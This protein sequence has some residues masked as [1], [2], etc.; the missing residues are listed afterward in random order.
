MGQK[1]SDEAILAALLSSPS[2]TTAAKLLHTTKQTVCRRLKSPELREK[3]EEIRRS[4]LDEAATRL[5]QT[6]TAAADTLIALLGSSNE[7]TRLNA[8][9]KI[10]SN[11][12]TYVDKYDILQ[13]L[14]RL[15]DELSDN[16]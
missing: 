3:F 1:I 12:A 10:L 7:M 9:S 16:S 8:A 6:A 2:A 14:D 13:R 5:S 15:E 4:A 11:A